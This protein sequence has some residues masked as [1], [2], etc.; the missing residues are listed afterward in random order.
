MNPISNATGCLRSHGA[1]SRPRALS[2]PVWRGP[3]AAKAHLDHY[4]RASTPTY[5]SRQARH[6]RQGDTFVIFRTA[7]RCVS[8]HFATHRPGPSL[9]SSVIPAHTRQLGFAPQLRRQPC[10]PCGVSQ[11]P[12]VRDCVCKQL[13]PTAFPLCSPANHTPPPFCRNTR[14]SIAVNATACMRPSRPR[15]VFCTS[16]MA[17]D[18]RVFLLSG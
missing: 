3:S 18:F 16:L 12:N 5:C 11:L 9:R 8:C 7:L 15:S 17:D 1:G 4:S 13:A 14:P 10:L 2:N 6:T